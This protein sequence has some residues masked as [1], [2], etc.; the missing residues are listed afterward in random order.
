MYLSKLV[1]NGRNRTV[2]KDLS[3]AHKLHQ[4]IMQAF[5]DEEQRNCPRGDWHI[6]FRQEPDSDLVL[7]Q[8]GIEPDWSKLPEGYLSGYDGKPVAFDTVQLSAGRVLQFRLKANPSK[9]DKETRKTIGLFRRPDQLGWIERKADRCGFKLC[10]VD[11]IPSPNV[12]GMKGKGSSPIRITT[13]LYQ[14]ILEITDSGQF[15][16]GLRQGIGRGKSYGCGLLSV[17][18]LQQ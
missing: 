4:R 8:S 14:G 16:S 17:A 6:L 18:R 2:Q 15:L 5:P 12:F 1:L 3:N 10:G 9:R 11:V 13:A 7:V